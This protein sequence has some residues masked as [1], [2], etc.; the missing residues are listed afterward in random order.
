MQ[1][2]RFLSGV[3]CRRCGGCGDLHLRVL[4]RR[5]PYMA[6]CTRSEVYIGLVC[7]GIGLSHGAADDARRQ[8]AGLS[9]TTQGQ[10]LVDNVGPLAPKQQLL[11]GGRARPRVARQQRDSWALCAAVAAVHA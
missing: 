8:G 5:T 7:P 3:L 4:T 10:R 11:G 2:Y 6:L 9:L 1:V